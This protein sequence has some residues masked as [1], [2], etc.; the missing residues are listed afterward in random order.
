MSLFCVGTGSCP[1]PC[2]WPGKAVAD[3]QSVWD[4]TTYMGETY[5][6]LDPYFFLAWSSTGS[7]GHLDTEPVNGKSF[8]SNFQNKILDYV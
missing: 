1:A 5:R 7:C 6:L 2:C 8:L 4:T 3:G